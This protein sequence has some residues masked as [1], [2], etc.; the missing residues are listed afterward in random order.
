MKV[1]DAVLESG[2]TLRRLENEIAVM[3]RRI[4]RGAGERARLAHPD[5]GATGFALLTTLGEHGPRRAAELAD[6]FSLD[7]G[8]VSRL[9]HQ[10]LE[11][12]LI[13][14]T[15]DPDDGRASV[16]AISYAGQARIAHVSEVG[17]SRF[18]ARLRAWSHEDLADLTDRITA[19]NQAMTG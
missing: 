12:G 15:P 11:L 8:A 18:E 3:V 5:L 14:R 16:L 2:E 6:L 10:L 7:K 13:E 1:A 4:R 17:R 9:V 19:F